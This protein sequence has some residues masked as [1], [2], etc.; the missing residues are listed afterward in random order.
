MSA[1]DVNTPKPAQE[2]AFPEDPPGPKRSHT[3][4]ADVAPEAAADVETQQPPPKKLLINR[5]FMRIGD[6]ETPLAESTVDWTAIEQCKINPMA[7]LLGAA[8]GNKVPEVRTENGEA[9][10]KTEEVKPA[11]EVKEEVKAEA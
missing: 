4:A 9:K 7:M 8:K 2:D 3:C 5:T 1:A 11:N 6:V 10:T